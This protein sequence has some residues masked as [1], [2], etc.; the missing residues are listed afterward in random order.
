M[1]VRV[2]FVCFVASRRRHTRCALVTGVQRVLFRSIPAVT[3][4]ST[5][6]LTTGLPRHR[7]N[8]LGTGC[9]ARS[10]CPAATTTAAAGTPGPVPDS[11]RS[12]AAIGSASCRERVCQDVVI[13]VV[14]V[15]LQT[16]NQSQYI[17]HT[18]FN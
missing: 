15:I 4:A 6:C 18:R 2:E 5:E 12:C 14:A 9:P 13:S 7:A 16:N 8:C 1:L 17:A 10:P 11:L 3:S